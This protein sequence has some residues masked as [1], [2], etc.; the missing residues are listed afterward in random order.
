[1]FL[2]YLGIRTF[3]ARPAERA[4]PVEARYGWLPAYLST[5]GLTLT[6]PAT[7]I[8]FTVIFAGLRLSDA[9]GNYLSAA[10][11]VLGVLLGSAAWWLTL[12][13]IVGAFRERFTRNWLRW[14][15]R[16]AG[17]VIFGFGVFALLLK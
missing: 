17:A 15:N 12:S 10:F 1:M 8:S 9:D 16:L 2:V 3:I 14:V 11:M 5:L 7:I 4:A 6:N 13:S